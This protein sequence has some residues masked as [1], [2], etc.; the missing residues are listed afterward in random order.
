MNNPYQAPTDASHEGQT[1]YIVPIDG[2]AVPVAFKVARGWWSGPKLFIDG[3]PAGKSSR[4]GFG[5][6]MRDGTTAELRIVWSLT[7]RIPRVSVNGR[8]YGEGGAWDGWGYGVLIVFPFVFFMTG[9]ALGG[10]FGAAAVMVN[11]Q[12]AF[13]SARWWIKVPSMLAVICA[14]GLAYAAAAG[15][16]YSL[17]HRAPT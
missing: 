7:R 16:V 3:Q 11:R 15:L 5:L 9:G 8:K 17:F 6:P 4:L 12:V 10:L 1:E 13:S 14:V 2:A